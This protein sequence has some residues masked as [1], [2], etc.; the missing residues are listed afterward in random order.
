[1]KIPASLTGKLLSIKPY[2]FTDEKTGEKFQ[3]QTIEIGYEEY[4]KVAVSCPPQTFVESQ[5]G[6][7]VTILAQFFV[8]DTLYG[9]S[10]KLKYLNFIE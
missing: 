10:T 1:M 9:K 6:D 7:E 3:G 5:I 4:G 8:P 2:D